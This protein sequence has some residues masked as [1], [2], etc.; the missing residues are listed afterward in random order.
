MP[1]ILAIIPARGGSKEIPN[2]NIVKICGKP[3]I[4]YS[5]DLSL[6]LDFV[7]RVIVTTDDETISSVS[8]DFGAEVFMRSS[9]SLSD[10]IIMPDFAILDVLD[11]LKK[12]SYSPDIVIFLQP[13]SPIRDPEDIINAMEVFLSKSA[14][15][16]LSVSDM[17]PFVWREDQDGNVFSFNYD[18][19]NRPRRQ[20]APNDFLENGSF[21]IFKPEILEKNKTRLGGKIVH[22]PLS[23]VKSFQIDNEGDLF[24]VEQ[25][26]RLKN[27]NNS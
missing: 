11:Q 7:N 18:Y 5:I 1:E 2:K 16:L 24:I 26:M 27:E 20:D 17:H 6:G 21:Y 12:E 19:L 13:T 23:L 10:D 15:S 22:Y 25:L 8:K 3:L 14:D 9:A 4:F